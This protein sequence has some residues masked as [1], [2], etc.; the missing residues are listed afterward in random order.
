MN[1]FRMLGDLQLPRIYPITDTSISGISHCEQV[2]K[3]LDGGARFIQIRDKAA[4]SRD[5][6]DS[7]A[8][9]LE[10]ARNR[11]ARLIVNDRVDIAKILGADGVHLGQDDLPPGDARELLGAGA[12]IGF[13]TH[14]LEQVREARNLP[15][16][17]IAFGPIFET[18]TKIDHDPVVGLEN[19][20]RVRDAVGDFP[21]VAIGG[22]DQD[23]MLS[24]LDAGADSV[25][26]IS[27]FL[28]DPDRI[29]EKVKKAIEIADSER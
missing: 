12:I 24:V 1:T 4:S 13:S 15:V 19:L 17:Y 27:A 28:S 22:I 14:D 10:I 16:D 11:G 20:K 29:T 2:G 23:N 8:S 26:I 18:S 25:A 5:F 3:M 21:L 9:C 6:F 7:A